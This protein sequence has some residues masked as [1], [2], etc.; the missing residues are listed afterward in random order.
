PSRLPTTVRTGGSGVGAPTKIGAGLRPPTRILARCENAGPVRKKAPSGTGPEGDS[1]H[2]HRDPSPTDSTALTCIQDAS[3]IIAGQTS[4]CLQRSHG[5]SARR[6]GDRRC[7]SIVPQ[8][9][10]IVV[11]D[12]AIARPVGP[13]PVG[14]PIVFRRA[15]QLA[16]GHVGAIAA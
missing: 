11:V 16:L 13:I 5:L 9:R 15:L 2:G 6:A 12:G 4:A 8:R 3:F 7:P 14:V 1:N 10:L